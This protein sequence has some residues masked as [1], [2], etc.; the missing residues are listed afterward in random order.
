MSW[1]TEKN[2]TIQKSLRGREGYMGEEE[3]AVIPGTFWGPNADAVKKAF[4]DLIQGKL[5][6][7]PWAPGAETTVGIGVNNTYWVIDPTSIHRGV[8]VLNAS[9]DEASRAANAVM[10][11][12]QYGYYIRTSDRIPPIAELKAA[13]FGFGKGFTEA[14]YQFYPDQDPRPKASPKIEV[15]EQAPVRVKTFEVVGMIG[16]SPVPLTDVIRYVGGSDYEL[17]PGASISVTD[18]ERE[19]FNLAGSPGKWPLVAGNQSPAQFGLDRDK[20]VLFW[21]GNTGRAEV[22]RAK[23]LMDWYG[24]GWRREIYGAQ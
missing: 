19:G 20:G 5:T 8:W 13:G 17:A 2:E 22:L 12:T 15:L 1:W 9:S 3:L 6:D 16:G 11:P 21:N 10:A 24:P 7:K 14:Y 4:P 18:N 23:V